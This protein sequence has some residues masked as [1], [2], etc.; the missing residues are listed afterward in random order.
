MIPVRLS[1]LGRLVV[2][3]ALVGLFVASSAE[4]QT[5]AKPD[6]SKQLILVGLRPKL[7]NGAG[8][9]SRLSEAQS[10]RAIAQDVLV[11][12]SGQPVLSH[13]EL[14]KMLGKKYLV[15][16]FQC[17]GQLQCIIKML[18]PLRNSGFE[19][20]ITGEYV[21]IGTVYKF[22]L[23]S[24]TL[25]DGKV[26]KDLSFELPA[27]SIKDASQWRD[28]LVPLGIKRSGRVVVTTNVTDT[29]CTVD[30]A[31]C[32][33]EADGQTLALQPGEHTIEL[34]KE[35]YSPSRVVVTVEAGKDQEV[36]IAL[37]PSQA[38]G[39]T[40]PGGRSVG[41]LGE[42]R[43]APTLTGIRTDKP[44]SI[45][46]KV[47]E[48]QWQKAWLESNLTQN[49]PDEG[50]PPTERT[51]LRVLYDDNAIYIAIRCFDRSPDKIVARLTRRDREIDADKVSV[52]I[53]SRNDKKT[54]YTFQVNAAGVQVDG[55]RFND[56]EYS[57]DWDGRWYS[58]VTRDAQ[59]WNAELKI[60]LVT[61][62][63]AGDVTSFG[64][65]VR[66][67]I[68]R[69]G[70]IDE[71][72]YI[73]TTAGREVSYYGTLDGITGL[74]AKRLFQVLAYDSR[75]FFYRSGQGELNGGSSTDNLGA[76]VK[77]GLTPGLTIDGTINPDFGTVEVDKT[78]L[79]L[80][81]VETYFPEKRPFFVEGADLFATP[82]TIF[83]SRRIGA[84]PPPPTLVSGEEVEPLP[85][86]RI[87]A[88]VKMTGLIANRLSIGLLDAVTSRQ[89][90]TI[91][92]VPGGKVEK[93]LVDP[94]ANFGVLRLRQD[95]GTSSSIGLIG[96][97]VNRIEPTN[98]A[99]PQPGDLC[100]VP[101]ATT[102]GLL[103]PEPKNGRCSND[104][105]TGGADIALHS[106]DGEWGASGQVVGSLIS[107]GPTVLVPD[108]TEIGSGDKGIGINTELG[109]YGGGQWLYK[110]GYMSSSPQFQINDVGYQDQA[111]FHY[112][113]ANVTW[114]R[115][116]PTGPFQ[117]LSFDAYLGHRR[118]WDFKY[119]LATEPILSYTLK[120]R[121]QWRLSGSAEWFPDWVD[122]RETQDGAAT[123]RTKAYQLDITLSSNPTKA[124]VA[125]ATQAL[126]RKLRG[127]TFVSSMNLSLRP[128]PQLE[129]DLIASY[130]KSYGNPRALTVEDNGD[131]TVT[132]YFADLDVQTF[133]VTLRGTYTFT[134]KLT[135]QA[136]LQP[137]LASGR[138]GKVTASTVDAGP[139]PFL[140][141]DSFVNAT[142]PGGE[143]PSA[144]RSG[145]VNLNVFLR[146]EY[147]PLSA[148]WLV[149]FRTQDQAPYNPLEGP[150]RLRL[151]PFVKGPSTDAVLIKLSYLW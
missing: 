145:T 21:V 14:A 111:N 57:T 12:V 98:D 81:T 102:F 31:P 83:Y 32:T 137:F 142:L 129:L 109:R 118:Q 55:T 112:A 148:L 69:T 101:Y 131:G 34:T 64:F 30:D 75:R 100:P 50:K 15:E 42:G 25:A 49:F 9:L 78:V 76:D 45:D 7:E 53:S 41:K 120:F 146:W 61:L 13:D 54:S 8:E 48:P 36:A 124:L 104:A 26:V 90:A 116:T 4:A 125:T 126:A 67:T 96:T 115:T 130:T 65:Q 87:W 66:R 119:N 27:G 63:Y 117:A 16:W 74:N 97:A 89:D 22:R 140:G 133:D 138:F 10:L 95:F 80:T 68:G 5:P 19:V 28:N 150:S 71:W 29:G 105:Y 113:F 84:A 134:R 58:E 103:A 123:E 23:V 73:P 132:Y 1:R 37:S 91:Q 88:A 121:N 47:D 60:P 127:F 85:D 122:N 139:K 56:T 20:A 24:F 6:P 128:V 43:M 141:L 149:Y 33:F 99:T 82:F 92:R 11:E 39:P 51:E 70:E 107:K 136:Y 144:F 46:G 147:L 17:A 77:I 72:S 44:P 94:L 2:C 86:G 151:Y 35:K 106:A 143:E 135:L 108:G 40:Q 52:D 3:C 79:N 110:V 18:A 62:R 93:L 59:G 38:A 114:R